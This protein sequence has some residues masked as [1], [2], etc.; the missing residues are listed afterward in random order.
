[1][2]EMAQGGNEGMHRCLRCGQT[3][4]TQQE[5]DAH[6][7]QQHGGETPEMDVSG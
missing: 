4:D 3:F 6:M 5:L 1:M 2:D 7:E